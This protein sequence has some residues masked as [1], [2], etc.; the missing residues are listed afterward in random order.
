M[1]KIAL[2]MSIVLGSGGGAVNPLINMARLGFGGAMGDGGQMFSWIHVD[3]IVRTIDHLVAHEEV[4]GPVNLASPHPVTNAELM[5]EMRE[6]VGRR[7]G[8]P[9]PAWWLEFGARVIRTE[10][11]LVLKS[12]WVHPGVLLDSG[13]DFAHPT[14]R[15][16]LAQIVAASPKGLLP[17]QLG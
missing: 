8:V 10:A 5:R 6:A 16:A 13:F 15:E 14:L 9:S 17:V 7:V 11:E 4:A 12:R 2:R 1:R 3:D